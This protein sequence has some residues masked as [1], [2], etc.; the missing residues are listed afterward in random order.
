MVRIYYQ[1]MGSSEGGD[2]ECAHN[3]N[4][5]VDNKSGTAGN[6]RKMFEKTVFSMLQAQ[7][8]EEAGNGDAVA[9]HHNFTGEIGICCEW[10][11]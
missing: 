8:I 9:V 3:S 5:N 2:A 1:F 10:N 7:V 6:D 4:S 11:E